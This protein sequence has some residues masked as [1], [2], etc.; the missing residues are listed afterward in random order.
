MSDVNKVIIIGN[1]GKE[2]EFHPF[3]SGEGE[4][5]KFSI[6]TSHKYKDKSGDKQE[7]TQWHNIVTFNKQLVGFIK[8]FVAK[9]TRVYIEGEI[10][11]R[12]YEKDGEK[13]Y[14]TEIVLPN[15]TGRLEI[16]ARWKGADDS[17]SQG[18][19][20]TTSAPADGGSAYDDFDDDIPF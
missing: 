18:Q 14:I 5:A 16:Q 20:Q 11:T 9:G 6:A 4:V 15:F 3:K 10:Q 7:I 13:K 1:V 17:Q 19:Q 12:S 2:P 8:R